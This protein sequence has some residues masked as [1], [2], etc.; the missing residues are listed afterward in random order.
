MNCPFCNTNLR[1]HKYHNLEID[2]CDGCGGF[3]FDENELTE[4]MDLFL[5]KRPDVPF[6]KIKADKKTMNPQEVIEDAR[7]CPRCNIFMKKI[8]Y[9]QHSNVILDSCS[10]CNGVWVDGNEV[11]KLAVYLKGNPDTADYGKSIIEIDRNERSEYEVG[12][13]ATLSMKIRFLMGA[14]FSFADCDDY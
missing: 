12:R 3:W 11:F 6:D 13:N 5:K 9:C 1:E 8:N 2:N 10:S 7:S 4:F 14:F